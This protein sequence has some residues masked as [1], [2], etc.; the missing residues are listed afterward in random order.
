M[1]G[2]GVLWLFTCMNGPPAQVR[3]ALHTT[4]L[5]FHLCCSVPWSVQKAIHYTIV[6]LLSASLVCVVSHVINSLLFGVSVT[7]TWV[8]PFL[9]TQFGIDYVSNRSLYNFSRFLR[10]AQTSSACAVHNAFRPIR[11]TTRALNFRNGLAQLQVLNIHHFVDHV[12]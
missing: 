10:N 3:R 8:G 9:I 7:S 11:Q 4:L 1:R 2:V 12:L 5:S 6:F